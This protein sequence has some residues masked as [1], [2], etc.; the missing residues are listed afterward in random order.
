MTDHHDTV[1]PATTITGGVD[2]HKDTHTAAALDGLGRLHATAQFPATRAGYTRLRDWLCSFGTVTAVGVEGT[3][4][5]GAGLTRHLLEHDIP[6]TE[7]N[8]PDRAARR[9]H[10]KNDT[11]DA[12]NAATAV[13]S[14]HAT[15]TPKTTTGVAA[16][17]A[18]LRTVRTSASKSRTVAVNQLHSL[19]VTAPETLRET[20]SGHTGAALITHC[21]RLRPGTDPTGPLTAITTALRRLARRIQHL[22][23]EIAD[24]DAELKPLLQRALPR[25]TAVFGV[26]PDTAGQLLAT[27][28]DNIDR[29]TTDAQFAHLC[30]AA[31]IPASS[32]RTNRHRLNRGGDRRANAALYRI[33]IVRMRHD[34]ATRAYVT[35]R[36]AQGKTKRDI[37]RC[38]KRYV[39]RELFRTLTTD[40]TP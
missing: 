33:V 5:Y 1:D 26:G 34:P 27:A 29:I 7:V 2:T 20:L 16:A 4:S 37:I 40:L 10:G 32:G 8:R 36:T 25:T 15:A 24:A 14:G 21:A 19:L 13:Q 18:A 28:S 9:R 39:A 35:K 6:V 38:L 30:G 22:T 12:I 23:S 3:S 11:L 31:P 17:A